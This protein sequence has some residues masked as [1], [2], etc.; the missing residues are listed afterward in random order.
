MR[1]LLDVVLVIALLAVV[2]FGAYKLGQLVDN[3][4]N[5]VSSESAGTT[6]ASSSASHDSRGPSRHTVEVVLVAVVGA[7]G[8]L[9]LVSIGGSFVRKRRRQTWRSP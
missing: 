3:K 6:V 8:V 7:A 2:G 5:E 9:V 4:S 1:R